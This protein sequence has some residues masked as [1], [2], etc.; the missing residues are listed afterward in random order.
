MYTRVIQKSGKGERKRGTTRKSYIPASFPRFSIE[1]LILLHS[2][3]DF[4]METRIDKQGMHRKA[5]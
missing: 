4:D 1:L 2:R 3:R 5:I